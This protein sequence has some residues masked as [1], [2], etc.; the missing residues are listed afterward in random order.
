MYL[1]IL[2]V[3]ALC[4][5]MVQSAQSQAQA[6]QEDS[7][8]VKAEPVDSYFLNDRAITRIPTKVGLGALTAVGGAAGLLIV[9]NLTDEDP[10]YLEP[11]GAV[12]FG[13]TCRIPAWCVLGR[14]GGEFLLDD[15]RGVWSDSWD[16][17]SNQRRQLARG[18]AIL[19][20]TNNSIR[21]IPATPQAVSQP[22]PIQVAIRKVSSA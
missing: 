10:H 21:A 14:S 3:L 22:Q 4:A 13:G 19:W 11:A 20:V 18:G 15:M 6:V 7:L 5:L 16:G 1:H 8:A 2:I 12:A 9:W 17:C